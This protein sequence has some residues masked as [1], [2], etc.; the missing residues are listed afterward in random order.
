MRLWMSVGS[1][2][3]TLCVACTGDRVE[4]TRGAL[5]EGVTLADCVGMFAAALGGT[6]SQVAREP[7]PGEAP[8]ATGFVPGPG[9]PLGTAST[10]EEATALPEFPPEKHCD[11]DAA[12]G[13]AAAFH[14]PEL[15][16]CLK[17]RSDPGTACSTLDD[18]ACPPGL[19]KSECTYARTTSANACDSIM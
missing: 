1:C 14:L 7:L 13:A 8:S 18:L 6:C 16:D 15:R 4:Q 2:L 17:A 12:L 19:S 3:A 10:D 11:S 5:A 9:G